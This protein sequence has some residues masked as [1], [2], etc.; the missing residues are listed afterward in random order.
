MQLSTILNEPHVEPLKF[1]EFKQRIEHTLTFC[2][3][4][5]LFNHLFIDQIDPYLGINRIELH[6]F[7]GVSASH[8]QI[9]EEKGV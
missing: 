2:P 7:Q 9:L 3:D 4:F 1:S 8:D 5:N 6:N